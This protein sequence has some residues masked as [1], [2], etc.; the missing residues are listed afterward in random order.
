MGV[1]VEASSAAEPY[2]RALR[3]PAQEEYAEQP[4]V[5]AQHE[6]TEKQAARNPWWLRLVTW[7]VVAAVVLV[8]IAFLIGVVY[9]VHY[10]VD[11]FVF[12]PLFG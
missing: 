2:A 3:H 5:E 1:G 7:P 8:E 12:G 6:D 4:N 11:T 10:L 9:V